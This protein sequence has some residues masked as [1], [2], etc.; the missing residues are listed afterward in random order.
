[1]PVSQLD[2]IGTTA[3][4]ELGF[5]HSVFEFGLRRGWCRRDPCKLVDG[6]RV[7]PSADIGFLDQEELEALLRATADPT[8]HT[9]FLAANRGGFRFLGRRRPTVLGP[10]ARERLIEAENGLTPTG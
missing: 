2:R 4:G 9:L 8:D 10:R 7:E 5:L 6:P 3:F 1:M